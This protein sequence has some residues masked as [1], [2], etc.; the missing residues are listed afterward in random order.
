MTNLHPAP[1]VPFMPLRAHVLCAAVM[2]VSFTVGAVIFAAPSSPDRILVGH[3]CD[4][5]TSVAVAW[6]EDEMPACAEIDVHNI[7]AR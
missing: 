3:G 5:D 6:E 1:R 4:T 2:C 7:P